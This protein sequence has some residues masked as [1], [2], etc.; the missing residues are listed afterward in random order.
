MPPHDIPCIVIEEHNEAFATIMQFQRRLGNQCALLHVDHHSDLGVPRLRTSL[1][2]IR[3]FSTKDLLSF[4]HRELTIGNF[5]VPL[6]YLSIIDEVVWIDQEGPDDEGLGN[7]WAPDTVISDK[8]LRKYG[9][10]DAYVRSFQREGREL[11]VGP[12]SAELAAIEDSSRRL[13][14]ASVYS[15]DDDFAL[16]VS[17]SWILDIDLD[18]F[19]CT[20]DPYRVISIELEVPPSEFAKLQSPYHPFRLLRWCPTLV[21]DE[22]GRCF[23]RFNTPEVGY[24]SE[25]KVSRDEIVRRIHCFSSAL[26]GVVDQ[27]RAVVI[28]RSRHSGFTPA[29]QWQFIESELLA[30]MYAIFGARISLMQSLVD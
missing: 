13:F 15:I 16:N 22:N 1:D 23:A 5:I 9:R 24:T 26:R 8:L 30:A 7:R 19:S 18:Y 12:A 29:D 6:I 14:S 25:M 2:E 4:A 28:C 10:V 3:D 27:I 21:K 20:G 17:K 11:L